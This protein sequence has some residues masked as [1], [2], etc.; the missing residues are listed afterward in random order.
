MPE[1]LVPLLAIFAGTESRELNEE[2][3]VGAILGAPLMLSTLSLSLMAASVIKS[4][5]FTGQIRPERG[6]L[7]RDLNFFLVSFAIAAVALFVPHSWAWA[8]LVH[9]LM[10]LSLV[11]LYF[12]YVVRT[13]RVSAQLVR[14][15]HGTEAH[16]E[17]F[18]CRLGIP[19]GIPVLMLQLA[20]GLALL[21]AG[22]EGFIY[23]VEHLS[24]QIG[25]SALLLSLLIVPVATELPEKVNSILWIRRRKDTLALGNITG[26]MVFQGSL[27]PAIGLL[28]TPWDLRREVLAGVIV[29]LVAASWLRLVAALGRFR[30]WHFAVNGAL[31]VGYLILMLT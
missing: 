2:V 23:G 7:V 21:V 27:L 3:G 29:T 12:I 8:N 5:G 17:M 13:L 4:R 20:I 11:F 6:G 24:V 15:G 14:E 9:I 10:A 18:L 26:A 1:T 19:D 25:V 28:L 22:A 30:V 31:Y 16:R